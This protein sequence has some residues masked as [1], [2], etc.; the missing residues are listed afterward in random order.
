MK[1]FL[2][3]APIACLALLASCGTTNRAGMVY[4]AT[5]VKA[6]TTISSANVADLEVGERVTFI[7]RTTTQDRTGYFALD[8]CK[9][10][11][12]SAM[13]KKYDNADL[14]V[15]PEFKYSTDLETIEVTGRPAKY[16]NFRGAN[17]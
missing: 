16:K 9:A 8:N 10:A 1:K 4:T 2:L 15:S 13:L 12:I 5:Q 11:A 17:K 14:V 6:A 7:Y 3:I